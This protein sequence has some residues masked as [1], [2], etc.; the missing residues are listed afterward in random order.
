MLGAKVAVVLVVGGL[1]VRELFELRFVGGVKSNLLF[2]KL[3][4][5]DVLM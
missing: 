5:L 4:L 2:S 3:G 1:N